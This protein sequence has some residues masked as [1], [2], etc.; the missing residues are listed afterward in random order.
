MILFLGG[1]LKNR[2]KQSSNK[3]SSHVATTHRLHEEQEKTDD[4]LD[5]EKLLESPESK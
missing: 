2:P 4:E 1:D 5:L 3:P